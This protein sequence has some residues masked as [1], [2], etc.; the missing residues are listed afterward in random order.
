VLVGDYN[1]FEFTDGY[2]DVINVIRGTANVASDAL[3]RDSQYEIQGLYPAEPGNIVNPPLSNALA[4][5]PAAE[6][7]SYTF[8]GNAQTIDHVLLNGPAEA[9]LSGFA[10][11]RGNA[12]APE[13]IDIDP[14]VPIVRD[15]RLTDHDGPVLRLRLANLIFSDGFED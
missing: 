9:R 10:Y 12:D 6:Q 2:A 4:T 13:A 14:G 11:A 8:E 3:P 1:A 5:L 7:Y 15:F